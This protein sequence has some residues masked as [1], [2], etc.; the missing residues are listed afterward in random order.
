MPVPRCR[1]TF[2][3]NLQLAD[4]VISRSES[5]Y[6]RVLFCSFHHTTSSILL[7]TTFI[8]YHILPRLS[9]A[10]LTL[11]PP[12]SRRLS[13]HTGHRQIDTDENA[14]ARLPRSLSTVRL[15][16]GGYTH[17]TNREPDTPRSRQEEREIGEG[18]QVRPQQRPDRA[19]D[20]W[21]GCWESRILRRQ[22]YRCH[23]E[24]DVVNANPD[25]WREWHHR[26]F[27]H[28]RL[29]QFQA[30]QPHLFLGRRSSA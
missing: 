12:Q 22:S 13:R 26:F 16:V 27:H 30:T 18:H 10:A 17:F 29:L 28:F 14:S 2:G 21:P 11:P 15:I 1:V 19:A 25:G 20:H 4:P 3:K 6:P 9:L 8:S 7:A 24:P 5:G 23:T